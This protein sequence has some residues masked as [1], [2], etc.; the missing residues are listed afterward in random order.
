MRQTDLREMFR[1]FISDYSISQSH[2][3]RIAEIDYRLLSEWKNDKADL[4]DEAARRLRK[5]IT[6]YSRAIDEIK[7]NNT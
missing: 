5:T 6:K 1:V 4:P 3:A 7:L 2:F